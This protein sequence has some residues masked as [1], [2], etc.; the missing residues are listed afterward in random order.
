MKFV[1]NQ[2]M[3]KSETRRLLWVLAILFA[4]VIVVQYFEL[5]YGTVTVSFSL[6]SLGWWNSI[7]MNATNHVANVS[8]SSES[9]TTAF[10]NGLALGNE[11]GGDDKGDGFNFAMQTSLAPERATRFEDGNAVELM[12]TISPSLSLSPSALPPNTTSIAFAVSPSPEEAT[13]DKNATAVLN[14]HSLPSDHSLSCENP[15]VKKTALV[16]KAM[17]AVS[18]SEMKNMLPPNHSSYLLIVCLIPNPI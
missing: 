10:K 17:A 2:S 6:Q 5:P 1:G 4:L 3:F 7:S 8:L 13:M 12:P 15:L 18:I 9:E 14:P 11:G 16:N